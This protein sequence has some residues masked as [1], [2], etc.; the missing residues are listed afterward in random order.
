MKITKEQFDVYERFKKRGFVN[1]R[2]GRIAEVTDL[3]EK[4]I[5][6]IQKNYEVLKE[7]YKKEDKCCEN[8]H[9]MGSYGNVTHN[10]YYY[11]IIVNPITKRTVSTSSPW[12]KVCKK[13]KADRRV[14]Q[15]GEGVFDNR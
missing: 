15:S 11:E 7:K 10:V 12:K 14:E 4:E 6:H 9:Y 1:V 2:L 3:E 5:I 8:C 13:W